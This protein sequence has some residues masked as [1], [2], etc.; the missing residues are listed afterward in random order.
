MQSGPSRIGQ[1]L[2]SFNIEHISDFS[3]RNVERMLVSLNPQICGIKRS[4]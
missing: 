4:L 3:Y 1:V 2:E